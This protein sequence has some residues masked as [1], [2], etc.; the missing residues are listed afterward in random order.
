MNNS[1]DWEGRS[2]VVYTLLRLL[3]TFIVRVG[4][5][6]LSVEGSENCPLS[7]PVF[8]MSN[9]QSNLDPPLV[10][11]SIPRPTSIPGKMS[12]FAVPVLGWI[13]RRV[14]A[15]PVDRSTADVGS[16][17]RSV[18]VLRRHGVLSMFPEM[19]RTRSGQIG[20]FAPALTKIAIR[21]RVPILPVGIAG[22]R[23]VLAPGMRLPRLR[24]PMAVYVGRPFD[25]A[26]YYDRRLTAQDVEEATAIVRGHVLDLSQKAEE[27][28]SQA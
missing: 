25:L 3:V 22:M 28:I 20:P 11:W 5:I 18:A 8:L 26:E 4:L 12:L 24:S 19:S 23:N 1:T 6:R 9:H 13:L 15:F 16:I 14:G 17:R 2:Y 21:E 27:R 7:G 10:A